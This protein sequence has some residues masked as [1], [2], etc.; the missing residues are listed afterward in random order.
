MLTQDVGVD[1]QGYGGV[2]M[3][4]AGGDDVDGDSREEQRGRVQAA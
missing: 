3:A 4:E 2:G 1:T